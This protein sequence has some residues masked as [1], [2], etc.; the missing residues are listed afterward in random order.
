LL[1]GL[2][3]FSK[4]IN[5]FIFISLV[6]SLFPIL[7]EIFSLDTRNPTPEERRKLEKDD[8]Y[9]RMALYTAMILSWATNVELLVVMGTL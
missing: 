8:A 9:F 4:A 1:T 5:P 3:L 2:G 7:D 6:Y